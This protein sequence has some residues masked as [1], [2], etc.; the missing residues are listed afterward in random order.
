MT[1]NTGYLYP[2]WGDR[3]VASTILGAGDWAAYFVNSRV[4][5]TD[6]FMGGVGLGAPDSWM[7]AVEKV[8]P[9]LSFF[10]AD[11]GVT[12]GR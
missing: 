9:S 3:S 2:T 8:Q 5:L 12:A 6:L 11:G 10:R 7:T 4:K 1:G